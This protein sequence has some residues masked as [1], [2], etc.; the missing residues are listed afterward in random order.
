MRSRRDSFEI[1]FDPNL[2][3]RRFFSLLNREQ[4]S[5]EAHHVDHQFILK[6]VSGEGRVCPERMF[7]HGC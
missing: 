2:K 7:A 5:S 3:S 4:I 1:W 6:P